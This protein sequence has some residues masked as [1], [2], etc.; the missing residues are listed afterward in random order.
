VLADT[1][2]VSLAREEVGWNGA[3]LS[4]AKSG[5]VPFAWCESTTCRACCGILGCDCRAFFFGVALV[6]FAEWALLSV[7]LEDFVPDCPEVAAFSWDFFVSFDWGETAG[8]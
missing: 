7:T 3:A 2:T 4:G 1:F 8:F 6:L 5:F